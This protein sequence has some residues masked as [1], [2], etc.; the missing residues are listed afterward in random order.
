MPLQRLAPDDCVQLLDHLGGSSC[1]GEIGG[2]RRSD[3]QFITN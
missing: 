1:R 3:G 2:F